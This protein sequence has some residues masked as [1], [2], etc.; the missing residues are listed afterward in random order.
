MDNDYSHT[1]AVFT[2]HNVQVWEMDVRDLDWTQICRKMNQTCQILNGL[3]MRKKP[4]QRVW[5]MRK[6]YV[7]HTR[8]WCKHTRIEVI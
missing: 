8:R 7:G 1:K 4:G 5:M 6:G 3:E 2:L